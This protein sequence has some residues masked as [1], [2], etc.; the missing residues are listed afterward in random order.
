G[1]L[2]SMAFPR[3]DW[4]PPPGQNSNATKLISND[5][6]PDLVPALARTVHLGDDY[7][8]AGRLAII[9][10]YYDVAQADNRIL[11]EWLLR[12][13]RKLPRSFRHM[14]ADLLVGKLF[15]SQDVRYTL[16]EILH[17]QAVLGSFDIVLIDC[18]PRLTTG[19]I[20]AFCASSHLLIPTILDR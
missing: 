20:Q 14:L 2:S 7:D 6:T 5:V 12:C 9:T 8:G 11:V 4:L 3:G 13:R 10:A 19:E 1:S 16:A 15:R 18:P 17:S